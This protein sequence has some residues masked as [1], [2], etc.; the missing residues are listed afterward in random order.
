MKFAAVIVTYNRVFEL[1]KS[2]L[3]YTKQTRKPEILIIVDNCSTDGTV[4]FLK[5]WE[6]DSEGIIKKVIYL[7]VNIGGSG[8]FYE[9]LR[10][11]LGYKDVEWIWV[12]DD[13][14]Y[15]ALDAFENAEKV[16]E[17]HSDDINTISAICG[18]CGSNGHYSKVQRHRM[19]K[20]I[21]G[22]QE[23]PV[24]AEWYREKEEF[25]IDL[26][27]FVGTIMKRE[28]LIK[29]G[30]PRKDFFIYQDDLEHAARMR[31]IGRIL[32]NKNI[33]IKHKDN[34]STNDVTSWRDYYANRNIVV[35]YKEH[36]GYWSL[37]CRIVR[38]IGV[39]IIFGRRWSKLKVVL[40]AIKD[41]LVGN[42][43]IH[44]LYKPGC[45]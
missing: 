37:V 32:C 7:P 5:K 28:S 29:A 18:V 44:P 20:S 22:M 15:P 9:G 8:G 14:A 25:E 26:Y 10:I 1:K 23:L 45:K 12:A 21:L 13:D 16:I 2:V 30:L 3:R 11:A 34:F 4:E 42:M 36:F 24:P 40:T 33:K 19:K 39:V 27:S 31:K 17:N 43:G 35:M 41:G 6:T 38:R